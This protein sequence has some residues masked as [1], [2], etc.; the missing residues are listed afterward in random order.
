MKGFRNEFK[1]QSNKVL[2][3]LKPL[4]DTGLP[5]ISIETVTRLMFDMEYAEISQLDNTIKVHSIESFLLTTLQQST[6]LP[7]LKSSQQ[8]TLLPHCMEQTTA[9]ESSQQ[10]QALYEKLGLPL[11]IINA[12]CCGMSGLFGHE[13]ENS[14]QLYEGI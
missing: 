12:G 6:Q 2:Q 10:W 14:P 11:T 3:Q 1:K 9:K 8:V 13:Q 7:V 4:A 5:L